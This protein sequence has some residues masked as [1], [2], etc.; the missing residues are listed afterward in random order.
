MGDDFKYCN[1]GYYFN[2]GYYKEEYSDVKEYYDTINLNE[3]SDT[4]LSTWLKTIEYSKIE[5]SIKNIDEQLSFLNS[6]IKA[7]INYPGLL[8]G[9]G[10]AHN[11]VK[12]GEFQN[13]FSFDYTTGIPIIPGSSVKGIIRDAFPIKEH[14]ENKNV[15]IENIMEFQNNCFAKGKLEWLKK[16]AL[17]IDIDSN[18]ITDE[19]VFEFEKAI[20]GDEEN[21]N[22]KVIFFDAYPIEGTNSNKL[23]GDDYITKH[24]NPLKNPIPLR[25]LKI[26]PGVTIQ[27]N[28]L[29]KDINV[30][31]VIINKEKMETFFAEILKEFGVGARRNVG[32]GQFKEDSFKLQIVETLKKEK[33]TEH[34]EIKQEDVEREKFNNKLKQVIENGDKAE[35]SEHIEVLKEF[36]LWYSDLIISY[37]EKKNKK[38][39]KKT[40][41]ENK[42]EYYNKYK[43][44]IGK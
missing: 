26:L 10:Y 38:S 15:D 35:K 41:K 31:G 30:N 25:I 21:Q 29:I 12:T 4:K 5:E 1:L 20:F 34:N 27:F 9:I 2:K 37:K 3:E 39:N 18:K 40:K 42:I 14:L 33:I 8:V 19:F 44:L 23:L 28:F 17:K 24:E 32:Y 6:N 22:Q 36:E 43:H 11:S 13:G 7:K 16:I